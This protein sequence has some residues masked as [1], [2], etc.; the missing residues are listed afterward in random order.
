MEIEIWKSIPSLPGYE[1]SSLGRIRSWRR[2]NW[3]TPRVREEAYIRKPQPDREGYLSMTF[4]LGGKFVGRRVHH[5]VL[6]AFKRPKPKGLEGRHLDGN[7][8]NNAI[9]NLEWGTH[10]EN[11]QDKIRHGTHSKGERNGMA[12]LTNQEAQSIRLSTEP[13]VVLARRY[14]VANVTIHR[15]KYG[16]RYAS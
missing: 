1:A 5:L 9:S 7:H 13:G 6:E 14:N 2:G 16:E 11:E 8:S 4:N 15:I 10:R 3:R 12:K